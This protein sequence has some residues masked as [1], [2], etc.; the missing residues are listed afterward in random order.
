M[1]KRALLLTWRLDSGGHQTVTQILSQFNKK[2]NF[3]FFFS[4]DVMCYC[5]YYKCEIIIINFCPSIYV[6]AA[7]VTCD[8]LDEKVFSQQALNGI[9]YQHLENVLISAKWTSE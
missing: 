4:L 7:S 6:A 5:V 2:K 9:F 3:I 1:A 8:L